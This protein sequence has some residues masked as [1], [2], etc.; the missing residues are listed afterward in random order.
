MIAGLQEPSPIQPA[1]LVFGCLWVLPLELSPLHAQAK[2]T[3]GKSPEETICRLGMRDAVFARHP[4]IVCQE[5]EAPLADS[6]GAGRSRALS[7]PHRPRRRA[8]KST[9]GSRS[10]RCPWGLAYGWLERSPILGSTTQ[11]GT[12]SVCGAHTA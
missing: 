6:S 7:P 9:V 4:S 12:V 5:C 3:H 1:E 2:L 11:P 10:Y 8:M